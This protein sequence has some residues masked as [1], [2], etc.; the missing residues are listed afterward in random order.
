M[1]E[2][3]IL[4]QYREL[5]QNKAD[6]LLRVWAEG[7]DMESKTA[8]PAAAYFRRFWLRLKAETLNFGRDQVL[9]IM[10]AIVILALQVHYG[11]AKGGLKEFFIIVG[12]YVAL[13]FMYLLF[14][15]ARVARLLEKDRD[16]CAEDI[17]D[18][19]QKMREIKRRWPTSEFVKC[20]TDRKR[21]SPLIDQPNTGIQGVELEKALEWHDL[22]VKV[23]GVAY[24][25]DFD[26]TIAL[27]DQKERE[28]RQLP[29]ASVSSQS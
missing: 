3:I 9:A 5:V 27:L 8:A 7:Y 6:P 15:S 13:F 4:L 28:R 23:C 18:L 11:V 21:W 16:A 10:V 25:S 2:K 20:P 14:Q 12:P 1:I 22:F 29:T 26:G 24:A 19:K 17:W